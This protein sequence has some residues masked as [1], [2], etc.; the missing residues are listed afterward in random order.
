MA[1]EREE[2]WNGDAERGGMT[3]AD[4]QEAAAEGKCESASHCSHGALLS[5]QHPGVQSKH[6][7]LLIVTFFLFFFSV[8][9]CA[10][11]SVLKVK[12]CRMKWKRLRGAW[13]GK[14]NNEKNKKNNIVSPVAHTKEKH[15][16]GRT[17]VFKNV[18]PRSLSDLSAFF[19]HAVITGPTLKYCL[20]DG[21]SFS[22]WLLFSETSDELMDSRLPERERERERLF[23]FSE[24]IHLYLFTHNLVRIVRRRWLDYWGKKLHFY[25]CA[26]FWAN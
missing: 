20:P 19:P 11:L 25:K 26:H 23:H 9:L 16:S 12:C 18:Y 7:D 10:F 17:P 15:L 14:N 4:W 5:C 1:R 6:H 3:A 8:C 22:T 21:N 13:E 2:W 24:W